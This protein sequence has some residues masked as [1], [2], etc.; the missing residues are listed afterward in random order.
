MHG[1]MSAP[2]LACCLL[3]AWN[4]VAP[5]A[6]GEPVVR[7]G[8]R[9]EVGE[10]RV[11]CAGSVRVWRAGTGLAGST[12]G[13]GVAFRLLPVR[14]GLAL[15]AAGGDTLGRFG[16]ALVF[17]PLTAE[18]PL[19]VDSLPYRGEV[20][21]RAENAVTLTVVNTLRVDDYLRG[22]LPLEMGA[23]ERTPPAAL[24]A[25]AIA[26]RSYTLFYFGR[27]ADHGCDLFGSTDDQVYGGIR[28]ET[29]SGTRA[30]LETRGMVAV[31]R[32]RAIRANYC[33]TCGGTTESSRDAW[34]GEDYPYLRRVRDRDGPDGPL[35]AASAAFRWTVSWPWPRLEAIVLAHLPEE[36]PEARAVALGRLEDL[37]IAQ[38]SPS[39][40]VQV[41]EV[42]TTAGNFRVRGDRIRRVVR[43][44]DDRP[45][46]S[47][48][49]GRFRRTGED[50][51]T[52]V[53]E[54]GG[55]GH[56]VGMCQYGALELGRRGTSAA[57][58]LRHY[59]RGIDLARWW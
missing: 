17:E 27:R 48:L 40:R 45:L 1:A 20:T 38:R 34:R 5:A 10:A 23:S 18:A 39:G 54:G 16:E 15:L 58:I 42:R 56:G 51:G 8:V 6:P 12:F 13:P 35:C 57:G 19:M 4:A 29:V 2:L 7:V 32:G 24:Q 36:V 37:R 3:A 33:S 28:A 55:F 31:H 47:T 46:R 25:Q 14:P 53:L 22:V 21:V 9:V 49:W 11:A 59:Y 44:P 30:V 43:A 26:A 41:L 50:G 52:I